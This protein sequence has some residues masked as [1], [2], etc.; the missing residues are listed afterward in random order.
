[1]SEIND[2]QRQ[3][4]ALERKLERCLGSQWTEEPAES[5]FNWD[6]VKPGM[7]FE[8]PNVDGRAY[9]CY[10]LNGQPNFSIA[11]YDAPQDMHQYKSFKRLPNED[12]I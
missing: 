11:R 10:S 3:L 4:Q 6:T 8:M 1:M 5:D 12:V 7:C 2:L 9:Y